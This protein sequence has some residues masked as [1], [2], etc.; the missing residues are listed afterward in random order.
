MTVY[1]SRLVVCKAVNCSGESVYC[2]EGL[3]LSRVPS[4]IPPDVIHIS[5]DHNNISALTESPFTHNTMCTWLS[6]NHNS[7]VEVRGSYWIGLWE[8]R[9]LSLQMNMIEHIQ[10]SSF[11]NLLELKCLYLKD[12]KLH[13]LSANI[14]E[15]QSH[16]LDLEMTLKEN[17]LEFDS[18]LCWLQGG[19]EDGL[20]S[21][22][23]LDLPDSLSCSTTEAPNNR[24]TEGLSST[25]VP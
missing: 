16:P 10:H 22:V 8:L 21:L 2:R 4:D 6:L 7:L 18:R 25:V 5:L 15:P 14:F 23:D 1:I 20:I 13:T 3:T 24:V 19:V 12:N 17:P 9:R 11:S